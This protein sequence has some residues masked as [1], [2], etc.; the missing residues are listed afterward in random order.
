MIRLQVIPGRMLPLNLDN[1]YRLSSQ[2]WHFVIDLS[3]SHAARLSDGAVPYRR[4]LGG[5]TQPPPPPNS[6]SNPVL[7]YP[8][9]VA[10]IP[11]PTLDNWQGI[12]F[13]RWPI[14]SIQRDCTRSKQPRLSG[15]PL[16][17]K[18][19]TS[20]CF[21]WGSLHNWLHPGYFGVSSSHTEKK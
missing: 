16:Y 7:C 19:D 15:K 1:V 10:L 17:S 11:S 3:I 2:C 13:S 18:V 20:D 9:K 21:P 6:M 5:L 12:T 8:Y 14:T 4:L